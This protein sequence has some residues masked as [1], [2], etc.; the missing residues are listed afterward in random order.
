METSASPKLPDPVNGPSAKHEI[1]VIQH[2]IDI[3]LGLQSIKREVSETQQ[4]AIIAGLLN[5]MAPKHKIWKRLIGVAFDNPKRRPI[6]I[7]SGDAARQA[8]IDYIVRTSKYEGKDSGY[9]EY[10][11]EQ[12]MITTPGEYV[13]LANKEPPDLVICPISPAKPTAP[14]L[15]ALM[16]ANELHYIWSRDYAQEYFTQRLR[17]R[18]TISTSTTVVRWSPIHW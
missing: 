18:A 9:L 4:K 3:A 5:S 15:D 11:I 7:V 17:A 13:K 2:R 8:A 14:L 1:K 10:L 12:I 16:L 6:I